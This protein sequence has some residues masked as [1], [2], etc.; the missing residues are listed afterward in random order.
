MKVNGNSYGRNSLPEV[1]RSPAGGKAHTALTP[2][3]WTMIDLAQKTTICACRYITIEC[4]KLNLSLCY[5]ILHAF[6]SLSVDTSL[7]LFILL[8]RI[9]Y[10]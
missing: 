6:D 4:C 2:L 10:F 9:K 5:S 3:Y 7:A 8:L 1:L